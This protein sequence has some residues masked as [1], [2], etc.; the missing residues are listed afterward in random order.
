ME[1]ILDLKDFSVTYINKYKKVYAVKNVDFE[2]YKGDSLGI[3]GESGSGKSTLAMGVLR[4]LPED[5]AQISG[6]ANFS[7]VDLT[8]LS[9]EEMKKIRWKELSVIFQK[10]MNSLSPVH[11]IGT[12][13]EDIYR[14]HKPN[15][16]KEEIKDRFFYLLDLVNL[17]N[18]VY[19]LYPHELSGGM[20]QRVS[21][22]ISLIHDPKLLIMD[23][24]TTALDVV[25]QG[26]ILDEIS[27]MEE[28]LDMTRIM[29]THD[30]S[31]VATSCNKVAIVYAGELMELGY[32]KNVLKNPL[33]P[34]TKGLVS[35]F[36]SLKG[37]REKIKSISGFLPD[38][39]K[40]V[41]GCIFAPRCSN[42]ID[43][44]YNKKPEKIKMEDGRTICCHLYGGENK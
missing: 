30:M 40:R 15:A 35:S 1:P 38:L 37:D 9:E 13:I 27:R 33:H 26:Q 5:G 2:I 22:A 6:T 8:K 16:T 7:G 24:A 11:K 32:V 23:E 18:R 29:I 19:N 43:I 21:I 31:V 17:S 12:H 4:L 34:Y 36:P 3:V 41:K 10:S 14:I 44:C 28:E 42:A 25:T 20:L 39:S